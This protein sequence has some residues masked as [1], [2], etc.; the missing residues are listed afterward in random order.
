M[1]SQYNFIFQSGLRVIFAHI[2]HTA[3]TGGPGPSIESEGRKGTEEIRCPACKNLGSG[4]KKSGKEVPDPTGWCRVCVC[5]CVCVSWTS[6]ARVGIFHTQCFVLRCIQVRRSF[7]VCGTAR[8]SFA[9]C[10]A[11][12]LTTKAQKKRTYAQHW[13]SNFSAKQEGAD[14]QIVARRSSRFARI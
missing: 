8:S 11:W 9:S 4:R 3:R 13:D 5:V 6:L 14:F 10:I 2:A 1:I 12:I 7:A